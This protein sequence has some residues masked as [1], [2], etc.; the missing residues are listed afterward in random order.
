MS[1]PVEIL[2]TGGSWGM[3]PWFFKNIES[4]PGQLCT[5]PSR[6]SA[7]VETAIARV[8]AIKGARHIERTSEHI[9]G[10]LDRKAHMVAGSKLVCRPK[11]NFPLLG[12]TKEQAREIN[13]QFAMFFNDWAYDLR[14]LQDGEGHYDFGGMMWMAYRNLAGPDGETAG[15]IHY[16]QKRANKYGTKWATYVSV[17]DPDRIENPDMDAVNRDN[18]FNGRLLDKDGR[19]IGIYVRKRHSSEGTSDLGDINPHVFVPRETS[20]GRPMAWHWFTKRRGAAQR[21]MTTL[22]TAL[23]HST[24]LDKFDD[25]QL[26]AAVLNAMFAIFAKTNAGSKAFAQNVA[27]AVD[28]GTGMLQADM[29]RLAFY[30][31]TKLRFGENRIPVLPKDDEVE[32]TAVNRAAEDPTAFVSQFLRKFAMALG[33]S[34]EQISNDFSQVNYSSA[35][36]ALL[37]VWRGI[38]VER[39]FFSRHVATPI[40]AAV[41]EEAIAKGWVKLPAGAPDFTLFRSAYCSVDW[42]GPGMGWIDPLKEA[43][44]HIAMVNAKLRSR[45]RVMAE[46][47]GELW[48]ETFED[49]AEEDEYAEE[50]GIDTTPVNQGGA[51]GAQSGSSAEEDP[52]DADAR[53]RAQQE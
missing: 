48:D 37:E 9:A 36:A 52:D 24:M 13:S 46:G 35:R 22:V 34:F 29:A 8:E 30:E 28:T 10:G 31:K 6:V 45:R 4:F 5:I 12:F 11:I 51:P 49:I 18:L 16:D 41:I 42:I 15:V 27:P 40:Y 3:A 25:A 53:S 38:K 14:L 7:K 17:I 33:I 39:D 47:D 19:W 2:P 1:E 20:T 23:R 44:A 26:G 50:L 21:G 43:N 32:M